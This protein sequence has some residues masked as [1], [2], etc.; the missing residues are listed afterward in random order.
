M[1]QA[2]A[3][4]IIKLLVKICNKLEHLDDILI[5][6]E[7]NFQTSRKSKEVSH[8]ELSNSLDNLDQ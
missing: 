8:L 5:K 7:T 4:P 1:Q 2:Q 3:N 6:L